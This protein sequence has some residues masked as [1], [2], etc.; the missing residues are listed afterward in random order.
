M[1]IFGKPRAGK[2][3]LS[4][5]LIREALA[6]NIRVKVFDPHGTI[7]NRLNTSELLEVHFTK[8]R[9]DISDELQEIYDDA[10]NWPET[11]ELKLLVVLD[12]TRLLKAKNLIYSLN[13]LGKRGVGFILITQYSTSIPAEA[14]NVGTYFVMAAMS[15]NEIERFKEVTLHP[16]S[17]LITRMPRATCYMFSPYWYPEPFFVRIRKVTE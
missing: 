9:A 15:E 5:I 13:E 16:G 17:K 7:S 3:F 2:S 1:L 14:R 12:E 8:G 11:N 10:S 4:L 6:N